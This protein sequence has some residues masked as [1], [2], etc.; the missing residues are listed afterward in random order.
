MTRPPTTDDRADLTTEEVKRRILN[1]LWQ[2]G[3]PW[4]ANVDVDFDGATATLVGTVRTFYERQLCFVC[5]RHVPGVR[6]V[7]DQLK[8]EY[9]TA[10]PI[11]H[12]DLRVEGETPDPAQSELSSVSV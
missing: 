6:R 5:C 8:V 10:A 1:L 11:S 4:L 7:I 2:R 12:V 3:G 9:S